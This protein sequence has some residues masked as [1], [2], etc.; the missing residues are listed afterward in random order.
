PGQRDVT[1][2]GAERLAPGRGRHA[3]TRVG[4]AGDAVEPCL[5]VFLEVHEPTRQRA[6]AGV[7][8]GGLPYGVLILLAVEV[9]VD[10]QGHPVARDDVVD[11]RATRGPARRAAGGSE[12]GRGGRSP[13]TR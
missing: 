8:V 2:N 12:P 6:P 7:A 3:A 4:L 11:V 5:E 10:D 9:R 13:D 1:A